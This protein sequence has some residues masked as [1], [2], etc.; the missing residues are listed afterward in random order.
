MVGVSIFI[1]MLA[2]GRGGGW[3]GAGPGGMLAH[4]WILIN[5]CIDNPNPLRNGRNN[6]R[7]LCVKAD[8]YALLCLPAGRWFHRTPR[9]AAAPSNRCP[10]KPPPPHVARTDLTHGTVSSGGRT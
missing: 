7:F 4:H 6:M 8:L 10:L 5:L 1:W 9:P 2:E 3:R